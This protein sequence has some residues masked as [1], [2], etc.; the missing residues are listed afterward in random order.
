MAGPGGK[1]VGRVSIRVVPDSSKF[2][3]DLKKSLERIEKSTVLHVPLGIETKRAELALKKFQKKWSGESVNLPVD[4]LTAPAA[5]KMKYFTRPR[6]ISVYVRVSKASLSKAAGLL[7]GLSGAR[8]A[9]DLVKNLAER[10]SNLDRS[11]PKIAGMALAIGNIGSAALSS[12]AGLAT[13]ATSLVSLLALAAPM[14]ALFAAAGVAG[15]TLGVALKDAGKQL[16]SLNPL[17]RELADIIQGNFWAKAK[18]PILDLV[19]NVFPDLK[20]GLSDVSNA[21]GDW[22]GSVAGSFQKAFSGGQIADMM[23]KL[24][25]AIQNSTKGTDAFAE[26]IATLG[27]FGSQYLPAIGKWFSDISVRFNDWLSQVAS[28]GTL[29]RWVDTGM[30][31]LGQLGDVAKN[32]VGIIGGINK[33]AAKAGSDG[34]GTFAKAL[35]KISDAINS[36]TFQ[37]ALTE[38]FVGAGKA[39]DGLGRALKPIGRLFA[40]M[41]PTISGALETLGKAAGDLFGAIAD[42]LNQP[43]VKEGLKALI[44]GIAKGFK[45]LEPALKPMAKLLGVAA[46]F[47][48]ELAKVLGGVLGAAIIALAPV[49]ADFLKALTPLLPKLGDVFVDAIK[50]LA[51]KLLKLAEEVIPALISVLNAI[52]IVLP[53]LVNIFNTVWPAVNFVIQALLKL[54]EFLMTPTTDALNWIGGLFSSTWG[55]IVG[56]IQTN[57]GKFIGI[58]SAGLN[59]VI[60]TWNR[61]WSFVAAFLNGIWGMIVS[62]VQASVNRVTDV[63]AGIGASIIGAIGNAGSWLYRTGRDII[64]GLING[65][66]G[67]IGWLKGVIRDAVGGLVGWAESLLGINSPS[68]VFAEIGQNITKGL[69]VGIRGGVPGVQSDMARLVQPPAGSVPQLGSVAGE[70]RGNV[71]IDKIV[72][73]PDEDPRVQARVWGRE[74]VRSMGGAA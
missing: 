16:E 69:S 57:V 51:P 68:K 73:A 6:T 66:Q 49:L 58:L 30:D 19:R 7:A 53:W 4:T 27:R 10:L 56:T 29:E 48:G 62:G 65:I 64:S 5:A 45:A 70:D 22:A 1:S 43:G 74:F 40:D 23:G 9:G 42:A 52:I 24:T 20:S 67:A 3:A 50:N 55:G 17:W 18:Q 72:A 61:T 12:V 36:P 13:M 38:V 11:L 39:L 31:V 47:A 34:L 71:Y 2:K 60:A 21:L 25:K 46:K 15:I 59:W 8:L 41:A 35:G 32:A 63:V 26:S 54:V 44:D 37:K 33:A 28:D 14:P